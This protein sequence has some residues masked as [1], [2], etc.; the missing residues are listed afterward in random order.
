MQEITEKAEVFTCQYCDKAFKRERT[1]IAHACEQKRRHEAQGEKGVALGLYTYNKFYQHAQDRN[2]TRTF[3]DFRKSPYYIAFVKFGNYCIR[4]KCIKI[5]RFIDWVVR[6][7]IKLDAWATD[8]TYTAFLEEALRSENVTDALTRA[9]E[10]SIEWAA[11][12]EM[13]AE[14][15]LRYGSAGA[16]CQAIVSGH[17]SP[18]VI[19]HSESGQN[20]LGNLS[21]EQMAMV[22]NVIDPEFWTPRFEAGFVDTEYVSE[23][24]KGAGW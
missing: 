19:Y 7:K 24:L 22:W 14:D 12:R 1:L 15:V 3:E 18:W 21:E 6:S 23:M 20:M 17:L 5:E 10:Y 8:K 16:A 2:K 9:I 13:K 11:D 4:T